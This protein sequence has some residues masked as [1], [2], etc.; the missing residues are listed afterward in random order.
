LDKYDVWSVSLGSVLLACKVEEEI[1]RIQ[2]IILVFVHVYRR[3]RLG[4][5]ASPKIIG[6]VEDIP[7][8][9]GVNGSINADINANFTTAQSDILKGK[10]WTREE[11]MNV[12]R[13]IRPLPQYGTLYQEWQETIMEMENVILREMGFTLYWIP[14]MHPHVF[15]LYFLKV[16]EVDE[17]E[18]HKEAVAQKAWNYCNDS[19][20][21][22]LCVL[23]Q[24]ELV[25]CAAIHLACFDG[26]EGRS[27]MD[28]SI[29]LP[30]SP[31][32]WWHAFLGPDKDDD[33]SVICNALMA[34][35]DRN[36][37]SGFDDAMN[38]YVVSLVDGGSFCDPNSFSWN[39]LD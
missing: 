3:M 22:D 9:E 32:P 38:R 1:R 11:K 6:E 23:Y 5:D 30:L 36:C 4:V 20:R 39:A 18:V 12:L 27:G 7:V 31:K 34:L 16:L 26:G 19:C 29:S 21:I 13:Y 10:T 17:R 33:L 28:T 15:L 24:P 8:G 2:E 37:V 14:G 35:G 25:T